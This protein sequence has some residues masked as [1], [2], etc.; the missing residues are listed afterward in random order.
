MA[1]MEWDPACEM[2]ATCFLNDTT[3][4]VWHKDEKWRV[5]HELSHDHKPTSL[6]WSPEIG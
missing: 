6:A 1:C 2:L 5:I 3:C 4:S